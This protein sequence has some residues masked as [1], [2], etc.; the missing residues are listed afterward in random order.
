MRRF[1]KPAIVLMVILGLCAP[2]WLFVRGILQARATYPGGLTFIGVAEGLFG[3]EYYRAFMWRDP[4][5][6]SPLPDV[7]VYI[8][9]IPYGLSELTD[10]LMQSLGGTAHDGGL[11]DSADYYFQYRFENGRLTS[12]SLYPSHPS[13]PPPPQDGRTDRFYIQVGEGPP[14]LLPVSQPEL[15]RYGG[16]PERISRYLAN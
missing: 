7:T 13:L 2:V 1:L 16:R 8:E 6:R 9:G 15:I 11:K 12:L 14:F 5:D 10:E 3:T 4:A